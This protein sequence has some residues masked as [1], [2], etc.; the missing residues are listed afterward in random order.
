M[1]ISIHEYFVEWVRFNTNNN[2]T[3]LSSLL[4]VFSTLSSAFNFNQINVGEK[5][6]RSN[7][8]S[9]WSFKVN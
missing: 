7:G 6:V 4:H 1:N 5:L 9:D 2:I 3:S 8:T